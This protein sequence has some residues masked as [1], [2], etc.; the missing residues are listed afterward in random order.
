MAVGS[1]LLAN[2]SATKGILIRLHGRC[3]I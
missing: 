3:R 2:L 1:P